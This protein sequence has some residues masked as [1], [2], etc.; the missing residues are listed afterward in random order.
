MARQVRSLFLISKNKIKSTN[1]VIIAL[2]LN[3]KMKEK[4]VLL[5]LFPHQ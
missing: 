3:Y 2:L 5:E 4:L 1:I